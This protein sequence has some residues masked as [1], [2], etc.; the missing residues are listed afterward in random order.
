MY[1][2]RPLTL[3]WIQ[4]SGGEEDRL[5][6]GRGRAIPLTQGTL[7]QRLPTLGSKGREQAGE[8]RPEARDNGQKK[9]FDPQ[10]GPIAGQPTLG[11]QPLHR[12]PNDGARRFLREMTLGALDPQTLRD[13]RVS[14]YGENI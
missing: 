6:V 9:M 11:P 2:C 10:T 5:G 14:A 7:P 4:F 8:S 1:R 3:L 13:I 12:H